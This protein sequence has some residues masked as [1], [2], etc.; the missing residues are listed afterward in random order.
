MAGHLATPHS[1]PGKVYKRP[2]TTLNNLVKPLKDGKF[3]SNEAVKTCNE[4]VTKH[5]RPGC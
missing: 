3:E 5:A 4:A 1:G 2:V